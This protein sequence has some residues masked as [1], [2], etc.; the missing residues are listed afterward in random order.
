MQTYT[1]KDKV[2]IVTG[3]AKGIGLCIADE[4]RS[5]GAVVYVIDKQEEIAIKHKTRGRAFRWGYI[6]ERGDG[7][8]CYRGT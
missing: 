2:V 7:G 1:F 4:F 8:I 5:L 6:Q 3:G